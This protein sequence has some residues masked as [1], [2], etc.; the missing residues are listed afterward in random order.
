MENRTTAA[1]AAGGQ[2]LWRRFFFRFGLPCATP[3][4][5]WGQTTALPHGGHSCARVRYSLSRRHRL[6]SVGMGREG[7]G[8]FAVARAC[9]HG[10]THTECLRV[11]AAE[12][13]GHPYS[14]ESPRPGE[15]VV[16]ALVRVE[17]APASGS[18]RRHG[19]WDA[20]QRWK[21]K[22]DAVDG[23]VDASNMIWQRAHLGTRTQAPT[24]HHRPPLPHTLLRGKRVRRTPSSPSLGLRSH[25]ATLTDRTEGEKEWLA[26]SYTLALALRDAQVPHVCFPLSLRV[27]TARSSPRSTQ[28]NKRRHHAHVMAHTKGGGGGAL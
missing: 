11:C 25:T 12:L 13:E 1:A 6:R 16:E 14:H 17:G 7:W 3:L 9:V 26:T 24:H 28:D 21:R 4:A 5:I 20:A 23:T 19:D 8:M 22:R 27:H 10:Y 18:T 2:W 15:R